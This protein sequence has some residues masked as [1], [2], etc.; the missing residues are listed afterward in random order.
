MI[1][2]RNSKGLDHLEIVTLR[3][4]GNLIEHEVMSGSRD[5]A[6]SMGHYWEAGKY[7]LEAKAQCGHGNFTDFLDSIEVHPRSARRYMALHRD[8]SKDEAMRLPALVAKHGLPNP[9]LALETKTDSE[10][11]FPDESLET[12]ADRINESM[13][14]L[15]EHVAE[16]RVNQRGMQE[17]WEGIEAEGGEVPAECLQ[18][19]ADWGILILFLDPDVDITETESEAAFEIIGRIADNGELPFKR[20][21]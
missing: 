10:S 20:A 17:A 6:K 19:M 3:S 2:D 13:D 12:V 8:H 21:T 14:A 1:T 16:M 11:V 9:M 7:L 18:D 15:R 5:A 4:L